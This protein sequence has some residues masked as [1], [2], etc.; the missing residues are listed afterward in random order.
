MDLQAY[1]LDAFSFNNEANRKMIGKIKELPDPTESIRYISHLINSQ[2][3]WLARIALD[4]AAPAMS[5]WDPV[6]DYQ[7]LEP[8]WESSYQAWVTFIRDHS[9]A[10]LLEEVEFT[11]FDGG[12]WRCAPADIIQQLIYHSIHHRA[13]IQLF[14]RQQGMEPDFIDYIGTR[15]RKVE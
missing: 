2:I 11:G 8:R 5:W 3:K 6:Y 15:Y 7:E 9:Q 14:I 1:Y 12:K 13:Q 4:P 10:S